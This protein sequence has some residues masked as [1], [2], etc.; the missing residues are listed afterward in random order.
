MNN[1]EEGGPLSGYRVLELGSTAAGPFCARLMSDFGADVIKVEPKEGD[2]IRFSGKRYKGKSLYAASIMRNK[3]LVS[4]NLRE[5]KG[6]D[7]VIK[8]VEKCDV[9]V[10]NFRPGALEKWGL[11]Y[12]DLCRVKPDIVMVR[13][14][15]YGQDGPYGSR[16]GYGVICEA[17]GGLRHLIGDPDRPP[18]RVAMALTDYLTGLYAAFGAVMALL[19]RSRTGKGQYVD[20]A[21]AESA[22]SFIDAHVPAYDKLRSIANRG[23]SGLAGS[24]PNN[25][26]ATK[27]DRFVLLNAAQ[28]AVFKRFAAAIGAPE[29]LQDKG[30]SDAVSRGNYQGD[31][32]DVVSQWTR[33]KNRD[34][35]L[36]TLDAAGVPAAS[37]S[38]V[39][40][41]FTDPQFRARGMLVDA[42]DDDLGTLTLVGPVPKMSLTPGRVRKSGGRI[43]Q[44]TRTV[45][46]ELVNLTASD[47][48]LLE[49]EDIIYCD[50]L[51]IESS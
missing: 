15:G 22:L 11:G 1:A 13:I 47:L 41:V 49:K 23:G 3:R 26:Y 40:D 32:D 27:D 9:V 46:S 34:E 28:N 5:V 35:I 8:L 24:A 19:Y 12:A 37:V 33:T 51:A 30:F 48:R 18:A 20:A 6:R 21:L 29:L 42:P 31:I 4:I 10:E 36:R 39:A 38:T 45:L 7:L 14:S 43:G 16:P 25:L 17:A 44:D 50:P 2:S